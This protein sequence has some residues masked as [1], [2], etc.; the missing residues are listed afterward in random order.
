ML[1]QWRW[2]GDKR[3]H[4]RDISEVDIMRFSD[5][6]IQGVREEVN[7]TNFIVWPYHG[8]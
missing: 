8:R 2:A 3:V 5:Q 4:L 1:G 6:L 7:M